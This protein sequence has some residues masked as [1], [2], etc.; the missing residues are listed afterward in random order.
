M[1]ADQDSEVDPASHPTLR[2]PPTSFQSFTTSTF[3]P[4]AKVDEGYSDD[5]RSQSEKETIMD[6][7]MTLPNWMLALGESDRAGRYPSYS[8]QVRGFK[9]TSTPPWNFSAS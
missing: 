3:S 7:T 1:E 4:S 8:L 6:S 5:T 2:L 9:K